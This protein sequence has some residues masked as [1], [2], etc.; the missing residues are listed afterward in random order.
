MVE[1]HLYFPCNNVSGQLISLVDVI[2]TVCFSLFPFLF[3]TTIMNITFSQF[4][5]GIWRCDFLLCTLLL[6]HLVSDSCLS[7]GTPMRMKSWGRLKRKRTDLLPCMSPSKISAFTTNILPRIL[8]TLTP[9]VITF[10]HSTHG[11]NY[12]PETHITVA[13][14]R[15]RQT[16]PS[17][18][19]KQEQPYHIPLLEHQEYL[20][21]RKP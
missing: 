18:N 19:T 21:W 14:P 17:L 16:C 20:L 11:M 9:L 15:R 10:S 3:G 5:W 13:I 7:L 4:V 2:N 1:L 12:K 8:T 6:T